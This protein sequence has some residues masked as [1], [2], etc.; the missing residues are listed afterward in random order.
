MDARNSSSVPRDPH[1]LSA[2]KVKELRRLAREIFPDV[3][4]VYLTNATKRPLVRAIS[5]R[6]PT[7]LFTVKSAGL[8]QNLATDVRNSVQNRTL[9]AAFRHTGDF[10]TTDIVSAT[11]LTRDSAGNSLR[12]MRDRGILAKSGP[13]HWRSIVA[14]TNNIDGLL[15]RY[16]DPDVA[17]RNTYKGMVSQYDRAVETWKLMTLDEQERFLLWLEQL[18]R[19]RKLDHAKEEETTTKPQRKR[20]ARRAARRRGR[21]KAAK[22]PQVTRG[23]KEA[24]EPRAEGD[25]QVDRQKQVAR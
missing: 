11:G 24:H 6:R 1:V 21:R 10:T 18:E 4:A 23:S 3:S 8:D 2:L 5:T 20:Q 15:A 9:V 12:R 17:R 25:L 14:P 22:D 16:P 13:H 19:Q 7:H